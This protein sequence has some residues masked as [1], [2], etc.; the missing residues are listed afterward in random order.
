MVSEQ[1]Q[2]EQE[3]NSTSENEEGKGNV[4]SP[5]GD[6][7]QGKSSNMQNQKQDDDDDDD[8]LSPSIED[9]LPRKFLKNCHP[10]KRSK[11]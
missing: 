6:E 7:Q 4:S 11:L 9:I 3:I 2:E 8:L 1:S 10:R 5:V